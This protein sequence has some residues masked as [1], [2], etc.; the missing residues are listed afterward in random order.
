MDKV[1]VLQRNKNTGDS[2]MIKCH[3]CGLESRGKTPQWAIAQDLVW[4]CKKCDEEDQKEKEEECK[5]H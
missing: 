5:Q 4:I 3:W 1:Y 2:L